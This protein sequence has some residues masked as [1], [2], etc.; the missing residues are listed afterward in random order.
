[1]YKFMLTFNPM[2]SGKTYITSTRKAKCLIEVGENIKIKEGELSKEFHLPVNGANKKYT[3]VAKDVF[4]NPTQEELEKTLLNA[5]HWYR[6]FLM[7]EN[8][9]PIQK[10][11]LG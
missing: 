6:S 2:V 7:S 8:T 11:L 9:K 4:E 5:A 10:Y 3:L 1:M